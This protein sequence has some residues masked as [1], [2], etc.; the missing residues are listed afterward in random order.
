[1]AGAVVLLARGADGWT[2]ERA[3]GRA[4]GR[5][6]GRISVFRPRAWTFRHLDPRDADRE[7]AG[8]GLTLSPMPGLV[9]SVDVAAGQAVTKGDR[10]A[11][12]EAMKMEHALPATRD[13]IVAE[14]LVAA[15]EQVSAGQPLIRLEEVDE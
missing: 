4:C 12:L 5:H 2:G 7:D 11:V 14:V 3:Q 9:K 1:M 13:G 15:G 10:L 8:A 6:G